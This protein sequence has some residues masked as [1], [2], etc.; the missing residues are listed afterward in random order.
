MNDLELFKQL[1]EVSINR[2]EET[3]EWWKT[4]RYESDPI[5][6]FS[7]GEGAIAAA[8]NLKVWK[9][10]RDN[11]NLGCFDLE[12][13]L[14]WLNDKLVIRAGDTSSSASVLDNYANK[15]MTEAYANLYSILKDYNG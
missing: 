5:F 6:A 4:D 11:V 12:A 8:A 15:K 3:L 7:C 14:K 13:Y 9:E 2:A 1:I 10:L